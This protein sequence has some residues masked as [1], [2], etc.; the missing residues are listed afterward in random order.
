MK[1]NYVKGLTISKNLV[2][3]CLLMMSFMCI[4]IGIKLLISDL[5]YISLLELIQYSTYGAGVLIFA[6]GIKS[7][8]I[9]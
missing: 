3:I 2:T 6:N 1:N 8:K 7:I 9:K 4:I 5:S